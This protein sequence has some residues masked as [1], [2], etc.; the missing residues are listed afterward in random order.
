MKKI[1]SVKVGSEK[2]FVVRLNPSTFQIVGGTMIQH[3][4]T[5]CVSPQDYRVKNHDFS[6][7]V[8]DCFG[9][10]E[11][12]EVFGVIVE[13][14]HVYDKSTVDDFES[15]DLIF[16]ETGTLN[17]KGVRNALEVLDFDGFDP[18]DI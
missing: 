15:S 5:S 6:S 3:G 11:K 1:Q 18:G 17:L 4:Y 12:A 16:K 13:C 10:S 9:L 7:D 14:G 2:V 8:Y